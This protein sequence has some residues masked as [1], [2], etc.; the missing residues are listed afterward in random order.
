MKEII[1]LLEVGKIYFFILEYFDGGFGSYIQLGWD[2]NEN[3]NI[4]RVVEVVWEVD[5]VIIVVGMYENEN[6][7]CMD[8]DLS[9]LQ[10]VFIWVV[11]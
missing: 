2:I 4:F 1:V 3:I 9:E 5:V 10:E 6:W 7:D 11:F 8:F